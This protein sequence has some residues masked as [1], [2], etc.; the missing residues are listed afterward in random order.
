MKKQWYKDAV[1]YEVNVKAFQDSNDDGIGDFPGLTSR[2]DYLA[3]LG[4]GCLWLMPMYPS[5]LKD[6]GYDISD[7]RD[8]HPDLGTLDDFKKFLAEAHARGIKVI[9]DLVMNHTSDTHFWFQEALKGIDNPYHDYYVWSDNDKK[10]AGTRIIFIDTETS[11]WTF[12]DSVGQY[13]WHRFFSHQ[14]DLNYDN[15]KVQEEMLDIVRYWLDMGIDGFRV[16]AIPYLF[17]REG[18]SNENLPETHAFIKRIRKVMDAEYPQAMLLAEANQEPE[19]LLDFFGDGDEFHMAYHFPLMPRMFMALKK[20]DVSP[21]IEVLNK[22]P[23]I[24]EGCQWMMFLRNHDE[25]TLEIV[26]TEEQEYMLKTY[27]PEKRMKSNLGIRR[28]LMPLLDGNQR[29][30]QMMNAMLFAMPGAPIIYYG[31]EIGMGENIHLNDRDGVRTPMQ[32]DA[33]KNG[34]FSNA[35]AHNLILPVIGDPLYCPA[36]VNVAHQEAVASSLLNF[37]KKLIQV[38]KGLKAFAY[39]T[40]EILDTGNA[41]VLA[42][43]RRTADSVVICVFNVSAEAQWCLLS[44]SSYAGKKMRECFSGAGFP[45]VDGGSYT[46]MMEGYGWYYLET[47]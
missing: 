42:F 25:L 21:V 31:D 8:I 37:L 3:D 11:N 17:E 29:A 35:A 27:A 38:R 6:G 44:L 23:A 15:P 19:A 7:Y 43:V 5:P 40:I 18:T 46:V 34:G 13:Y 2:L 32:W 33:G 16:D 20:K 9:T 22:T 45:S 26:S 1:Y 10:Y 28:R 30:N 39:G 41:R 4:V 36:C 47:E 14:P 12:A 24:P